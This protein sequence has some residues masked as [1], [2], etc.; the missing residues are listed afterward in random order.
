MTTSYRVARIAV[1]DVCVGD[2]TAVRSAALAPIWR[3]PVTAV[4]FDGSYVRLLTEHGTASYPDDA[5]IKIK[6]D[7]PV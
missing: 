6:I 2:V 7:R 1:V 5:H 4:M 3:P